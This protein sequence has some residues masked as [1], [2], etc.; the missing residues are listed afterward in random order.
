MSLALFCLKKY[1]KG[2]H[3]TQFCI[4][5]KPVKPKDYGIGLQF[6]DE[7]TSALDTV[8]EARIQAAF[9]ELARG[10]TAL[11]IAHRLSTVRGA[12]KIAFIDHEGIREIGTHDELMR[13]NGEYAALCKAQQTLQS[14]GM[15]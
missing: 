8:T 1:N 6:I 10:R 12:D 9:D 11:V 7:A 14:A 5:L 2:V 4:P 3:K 15:E 13:K